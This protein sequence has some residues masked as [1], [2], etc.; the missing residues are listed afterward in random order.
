MRLPTA[1]D[2][3]EIH[4]LVGRCPPLDPNSLYCNL[5][6]A[7][8]FAHTSIVAELD[9][10]F[11]GFISAYLLPADPKTLFVWQVAVDE[12]ARGRGLALSML[13]ALL[14]RDIC[15][16]VERIETTI[17]ADNQASWALFRKLA[18]THDAKLSESVLFD[19]KAHFDGDHESEIL[20]S[21]GP[22]GHRDRSKN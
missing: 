1:E 12:R 20:V 10:T 16:G 8:H 4:A 7:H 17:T 2:G 11:V 22:L 18:E 19:R 6:Q 21:I 9:D 3:K 14:K 5:L 15:T 13:S